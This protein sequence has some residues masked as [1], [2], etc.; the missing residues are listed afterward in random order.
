[1]KTMRA[2]VVYKPGGPESIILEQRPLRRAGCS[3]V[4]TYSASTEL[5]Y[6]HVK[7]IHPALL[8]RILGI[9]ATGVVV[10]A[11][12]GE[13]NEGALIAAVMGGMGRQFDGGYAEYTCVPAAQVQVMEAECLGWKILRA[14]PGMVH[15]AWGALFS[16]LLLKKGEELLVR[17]GSSSVGLA[18]A[19]IAHQ[20]GA[21]VVSTTRSEGRVNLLHD[22]G[23]HELLIDNGSL[24][25][26]ARKRYLP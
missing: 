6:L 11:P 3:S 22:S 4:F 15:T 23:A 18:A 25:E 9:E 26:E 2:A 17:G 8:P 5:R 10:A 12:G 24:A 7:V 1:M 13:S 14:L 20:H 19:A 16:S 21:F